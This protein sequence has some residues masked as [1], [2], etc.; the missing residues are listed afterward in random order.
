MRRGY[1]LTPRSSSSVTFTDTTTYSRCTCAGP[2]WPP[3]ARLPLPR[4]VACDLPSGTSN[5]L[6]FFACQTA[7]GSGVLGAYEVCGNPAGF[8][9]T[10]DLQVNKNMIDTSMRWYR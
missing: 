8:T 2:R 5:G 4:G 3:T 9:N 6:N 7:P 1:M 10:N